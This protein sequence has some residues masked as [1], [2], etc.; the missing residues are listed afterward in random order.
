[1]NRIPLLT[2][3]IVF[4]A[5][6]VSIVFFLRKEKV[7]NELPFSIRQ[8]N[9]AARSTVPVTPIFSDTQ[10]LYSNQTFH[11]SLVFPNT[12]AV[13]EYKEAGGALSITFEG[14]DL[15]EFQIYVTPYQE[16]QI[17]PARFKLDEP[18]GVFDDPVDILIDGVRA[19]MFFSKNPIMGDTRE[20]WFIHGG[21]LYEVV[22]EKQNDAWL[23]GIM[24]TWKFI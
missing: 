9:D 14:N 17:T 3:L 22:T 1:M 7:A 19:T 24:Q 4:L 6:A 13:H 20:V 12:L 2:L 18:S 16:T 11:F 10:N 15:R 23:A 8:Q 21:F 5:G